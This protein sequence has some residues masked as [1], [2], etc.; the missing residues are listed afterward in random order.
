MSF[1]TRCPELL[2]WQFSADVLSQLNQ[3][4]PRRPMGGNTKANSELLVFSRLDVGSIEGDASVVASASSCIIRSSWRW[5]PSKSCYMC[6]NSKSYRRVFDSLAHELHQ[7]PPCSS[8]TSLGGLFLESRNGFC[9]EPFSSILTH[10]FATALAT[11][12]CCSHE[13]LTC[14]FFLIPQEKLLLSV[15]DII[16]SI[17]LPE[18]SRFT[19]IVFSAPP[20]QTTPP[21]PSKGQD[22][23]S[24]L[25]RLCRGQYSQ[26][27]KCH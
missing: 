7:K 8:A 23:Y 9:S 5:F 2:P 19:S 6:P 18:N 22:A 25:A 11:I 17:I 20:R 14:L 3:L 10:F 21:P 13:L 26:S 1:A 16:V 15:E 27:G 12:A 24:S 4:Q